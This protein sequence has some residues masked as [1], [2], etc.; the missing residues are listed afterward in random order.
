MTGGSN[1]L[2]KSKEAFLFADGLTGWLAAR[3]LVWRDRRL[4]V[5]LCFHDQPSSDEF[6]DF[7]VLWWQK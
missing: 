7:Y 4:F 3:L 2:L 5:Q 1:E 6:I